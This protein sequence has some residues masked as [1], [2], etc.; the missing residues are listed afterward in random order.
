M[1]LLGQLLDTFALQPE[2]SSELFW[3]FAAIHYLRAYSASLRRCK[4]CLREHKSTSRCLRGRLCGQMFSSS[5]EVHFGGSSWKIAA[6][7]S[8]CS[9]G[10]SG[11][12]ITFAA[13]VRTPHRSKDLAARK[14]LLAQNALKDYA[15]AYARPTRSLREDCR[16][17]RRKAQ[18]VHAVP[19]L[20]KPFHV[21]KDRCSSSSGRLAFPQGAQCLVNSVDKRDF[22]IRTFN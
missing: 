8:K 7:H 19:F 9:F 16:T 17:D 20:K 1:C 15:N 22:S 14:G 5:V 13:Q 18:E 6:L 3:W 11:S 4:G 12:K 21:S 2:K 10:S